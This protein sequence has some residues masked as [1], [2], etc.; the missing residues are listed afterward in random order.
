MTPSSATVL[1]STQLRLPRWLAPWQIVLGLLLLYL[2]VILAIHEGDVLTFITVGPC[3]ETCAIPHVCRADVIPYDGR[4][5]YFMALYPFND[6]ECLAVS[7]YRYQRVL[8][9]ILARGASL[10][11]EAL[12]PWAILALNI[13]ALVSSTAILERLL[14]TNGVSRWY[15][16]VYGLFVGVFMGVRIS[17]TEPLAYALVIAAIWLSMRERLWLASA[18]FLLAGLTKEPALVFA[19]GYMLYYAAARRWR[20]A[21]RLALMV[22]IPYA[23]WQLILYLWLGRIGLGA[24][25]DSAYPFEFIP[26]GGLWR[27]IREPNGLAVLLILSVYAVPAVVLPASWGL[28]KAARDLLRGLNH[29]YIWCMIMNAAMVWVMPYPTFREPLGMLR[30]MVGLVLAYLLYM[31]LRF[32]QTRGMRYTPLW[33]AL[34]YYLL[35]G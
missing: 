34:S 3:Y 26:F 21:L 13:T 28:W 32:P 29:P 35:A 27:A 4:F 24:G 2:S 31:G 10:G 25:P 9:S 33:L 30:Y 8:L 19:G 14:A 5:V 1:S 6:S 18:A 17:T 12:L 23:L 15:A 20:D 16:L 7:A 11:Q 22:G